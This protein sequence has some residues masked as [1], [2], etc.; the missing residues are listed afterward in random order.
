M[1]HHLKRAKERLFAFDFNGPPMDGFPASY[2]LFG[3][4][5]MV[6]VPLPGHTP[7]GVA[8]L[9]RGNEGVTW[10]FSGDTT[11]TSRGVELPAH[12]TCARSIRTS[13][14][15]PPRLACSTRIQRNR[16]ELKVVPAHDGAALSALPRCAAN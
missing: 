15:C 12:K 11:W 1:P 8:F 13:C 6:A 2:D 9:V 10:L 16:P 4:G 7:G 14:S 3:D 5:A